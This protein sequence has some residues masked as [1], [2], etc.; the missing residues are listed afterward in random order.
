MKSRAKVSN[1]SFKLISGNRIW[2]DAVA[3]ETLETTTTKKHT[4]LNGDSFIHR[5][6]RLLIVSFATSPLA[7][8]FSRL[9]EASVVCLLE[10]VVGLSDEGG[11][12]LDALFAAGYLLG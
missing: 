6:Y 10:S 7:D 4:W 12:P 1:V 3:I 5:I 8:T 11:G 2:E 9:E